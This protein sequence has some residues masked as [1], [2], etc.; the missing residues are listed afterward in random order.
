MDS[1]TR[2]AVMGWEPFP[3]PFDRTA[4]FRVACYLASS[5]VL[6]L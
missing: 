4:E 3:Q 6:A 1:Q 2:D 5:G